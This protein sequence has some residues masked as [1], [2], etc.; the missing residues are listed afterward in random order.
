MEQIFEKARAAGR[1]MALVQLEKINQV[2]NDLASLSRERKDE[3][4]AANLKDLQKMDQSNPMYDRLLLN[5]ERIFAIAD[6]IE[7]IAGLP[8]PQSKVLLEYSRP[9]GLKIKK[10]TVP[11]GVIG[12]I[13]EARPNVSFDVFALCFKSGSACILKGGSDAYETNACIVSLIRQV[14][15]KNGFSEDTVHL[16]PPGRECADA[17]M[18]AVGYVDLIIPRG[19]QGLINSVRMQ[20][21]IPVIETGIGICHIYVD[22]EVDLDLAE[23]IIT[24][25]KTRRVS[26]CNALECLLVHRDRIQDVSALC[27]GLAEHKVLLY[28]SEETR[29]SLSGNYPEELLAELIPAEHFGKEFLDYKLAVRIVDSLEQAV[30]HI[31]T[32][33]SKHSESIASTLPSSIE[34]F[35][36]SVD[37]ACVYS[38]A[39]TSFTDGGEFGF[40]A[41]IGI[42]TQKLHA[43]GPMALPELTSYKWI[44]EGSGQIR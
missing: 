25:S 15:Q 13:Y 43:R 33:G 44:I 8:F 38:N 37:A 27:R 3:I 23:R 14:L 22:R 9:N 11:F 36:A 29:Q 16:L 19:S 26:V 18:N 39:A 5:E 32:Y 7:L 21:R 34:Y 4:I 41:E 24:N 28:V 1:N 2:L 30:E 40:G 17:L 6:S 31:T 20:S 12:V 35:R 42:S 10:I